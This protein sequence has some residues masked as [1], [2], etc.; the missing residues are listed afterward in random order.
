MEAART[1]KVPTAVDSL[2]AGGTESGLRFALSDREEDLRRRVEEFARA[3]V[4][5]GAEDRIRERRFEPSIWSRAS[6]LGLARIA[7]GDDHEPAARRTVPICLALEALQAGGGDGG[8]SLSLAAHVALCLI[9]LA[10]FGSADQRRRFVPGLAS[11]DQIGGLAISEPGH[12]SDVT[13]LETTAE[14]VEGGFRL[15]GVKTYVTNGSIA[16]VVIVLARTGGGGGGLGF[17]LT[18]F[19]VEP[20]STPGVQIVEQRLAG[21]R[22]CPIARVEM[23]D[24]LVPEV[25]VLGRPGAGYHTVARKCFDLERSIMLAPVVGEM[26]RCLDEALEFA[27]TRRSGDR[28]IVT[29]GQIQ[30][31]LADMRTRLESARWSLYRSAWVQDEG[32]QDLSSGPIAKKIVAEA[33]LANAADAIQVMGAAGADED[34]PVARAL[35]DARLVG[36]AGGTLELQEQALVAAM[37]DARQG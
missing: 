22:S 29:F 32:V 12:G 27:Y 2:I 13:G 21:F 18:A 4:A 8:F 35:H 26:Q 19:L 20:R 28:R 25:Q 16:D 31:R 1:R 30:R 9:P 34:G 10:T 6:E 36:I 17:G 5:P 37:V 24:A 11:G 7:V 23:S 33:A 15:R 3:V 14:Q